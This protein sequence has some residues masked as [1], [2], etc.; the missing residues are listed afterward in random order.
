MEGVLQCTYLRDIRVNPISTNILFVF[1]M[2]LY[3]GCY[4]IAAGVSNL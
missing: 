4:S 1:Y 2:N 3:T